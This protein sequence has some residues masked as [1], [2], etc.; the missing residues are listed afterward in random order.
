M[1]L[2]PLT[3]VLEAEAQ[4][5]ISTPADNPLL[6]DIHVVRSG[7]LEV[8]LD[9]TFEKLVLKAVRLPLERELSGWM[10]RKKE[11]ASDEGDGGRLQAARQRLTEAEREQTRVES[12]WRELETLRVRE[13]EIHAH[14]DAIRI[15]GDVL[16]AEITELEKLHSVA[17]RAS[18]LDTWI[19]EIRREMS[20]VQNLREQHAELQ[21]QIEPLE[22]RFRAAPD[23]LPDLL[24]RYAR[25]QS[26]LADY[27][28]IQDER[29]AVQEEIQTQLNSVRNELSLLQQPSDDEFLAKQEAI[30]RELE[31]VNQELTELL[32]G[33]IELVRQREGVR[34]QISGEFSQFAGL[35]QTERTELEAALEDK[36]PETA[37][38]NAD[39]DAAAL[40]REKRLAVL[41]T[42]IKEKYPGFERLLASVPETLRE[43][44]DL[45]RIQITLGADVESLQKR[46]AALR[47]KIHP[48]HS[49]LWSGVAAAVAFGAVTVPT[50]WDIGLFAALV[51]S[52]L[53]LLVFRYIHRG[54]ESE[55][56]ST[57]AAEEMIQRRA[58]E[59]RAAKS[60][61][62]QILGP[63]A[64]ISSYDAALRRYQDYRRL[65]DELETVSTPIP[66]PVEPVLLEPEERRIVLPS[67]TEE[68][69]L[70]V[71]RRR[72]GTFCEVERRQQELEIA[73]QDYAE[74]GV[75]TR[76]IQ[77]LQERVFRLQEQ[78]AVL[79][80]EVQQQSK[81]YEEHRQRLMDRLSELEAKLAE[82]VS[83]CEP[84]DIVVRLHED[85]C[86]LAER[87]GGILGQIETECIRSEWAEREMLRARLRDVRSALSNRQTYDEL[88]AREM[89]LMEEAAEVKQQ[90]TSLDP[91]Y[92]LQGT[93]AQ[94]AAKYAGQLH[95]AKQNLEEN[96]RIKSELENQ[97][98]TLDTGAQL[99]GLAAERPVQELQTDVND[100]RE[101]AESLERDL[102]TT[103]ELIALIHD[104]LADKESAVAVELSSA[105][106]RRLRALTDE[107]YLSLDRQDGKP[108]IHA[109]DGSVRQLGLLSEGTRDLIWIAVRLGALDVVHT[110][111]D[112][113][114][115]WDEALTRL[116]D[117]HQTRVR[118]MLSEIAATRQ[119]ILF[120]RHSAITSWGPNVTLSTERAT[121]PSGMIN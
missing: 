40:E 110:I 12:L 20:D 71:L 81:A 53:A 105:I 85:I 82:S 77:E 57:T 104:E 89:L 106:D 45:R 116:D 33:R 59:T 54:V 75:K 34:Q 95:A 26:S 28:R 69:P 108:V 29:Q 14:L 64:A 98:N 48:G 51:A 22:E 44:H 97:A 13:Q 38:A 70:S 120:T 2:N 68:V 35:S 118:E 115:I 103:R 60:R 90:L 84:E 87:S 109:A 11:L 10:Q 111:D 5:A 7:R 1:P 18:R 76:R 24:E 65:A 101:R 46:T 30:R 73:W 107:R 43:Y 50:G 67:T 42:A 4:P 6:S 19:E 91:L 96:F 72:Y 16:S 119:V 74:E 55:M 88:R 32:R 56:E 63:L 121:F 9:A 15:Q 66:E 39:S 99:S 102:M 62:E 78:H 112:C 92:L 36:V 17:V 114:L 80:T 41:R 3:M 21:N 117:V 83:E 31:S 27:Q 58:E 100:C 37:A 93:A 61:I 47:R 86:D 113:P 8:P 94:Y 49:I 79:L 25:A 23:D 52:G